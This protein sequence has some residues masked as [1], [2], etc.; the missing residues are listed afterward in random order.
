M[1]AR[2]DSDSSNLI[3]GSDLFDTSLPDDL[4]DLEWY[5][6]DE[7]AL[8]EILRHSGRLMP[9]GPPIDLERLKKLVDL[10]HGGDK[11]A[12]EQLQHLL[13]FEI[14]HRCCRILNENPSE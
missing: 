2:V 7:V 3:P 4:T 12:C 10:Q 5:E 8:I 13:R 9:G 14:W 11:Q 1:I 6:E